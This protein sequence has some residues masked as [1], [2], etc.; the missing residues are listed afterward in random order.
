MLTV[1]RLLIGCNQ[2]NLS[3]ASF[4]LIAGFAYLTT[5]K[6][7]AFSS[8]RRSTITQTTRHQ[9]SQDIVFHNHRCQNLEFKMKTV[10]SVVSQCTTVHLQT[11]L[12]NPLPPFWRYI[13]EVAG[14]FETSI[15]IHQI[16]RRQ[17]SEGRVTLM[18]LHV[19]SKWPPQK[20]FFW[21]V[22]GTCCVRISEGHR[23]SWT[24]SQIWPW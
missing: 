19:S 8:K 1:S 5:L 17:F 21:Y 4:L 11:F 13:M 7:E 6:L 18:L 2:S 9:I 14:V 3:I 16:V 20:Y 23:L 15:T 24:V 12:K 10:F 22:F